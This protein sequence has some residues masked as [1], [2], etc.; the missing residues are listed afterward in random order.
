MKFIFIAKKFFPQIAL[1][2]LVAIFFIA[3]PKSEK[4]FESALVNPK[5]EIDEISLR[6]EK[7][8]IA[9]IS[10]RGAFWICD[11]VSPEGKNAV[12]PCDSKLVENLLDFSRSV[13]K[14]YEISDS[15]KNR[16]SLVLSQDHAFCLE[17]SHNGDAVSKIF[18]GA[19]DSR[20]RIAFYVDKQKKIYCTDSAILSYLTLSPDFWCDPNIFPESVCDKI[21]GG[22]LAIS[23]LAI[24]I[25]KDLSQIARLRHGKMFL[26]ETPNFSIENLRHSQ[27]E[28]SADLPC[29]KIDDGKG[30]IYQAFFM[31][32]ESVEGDYFCRF[33]AIP[34]AARNES[35]ALAIKSLDYVTTVSAWT[36]GRIFGE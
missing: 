17:F 31:P 19:A 23:P 25:E 22:T 27:N 5:Y 33:V 3:S 28:F 24:G 6:Y 11:Y 21:D 2:I 30:N 1:A 32:T 10:K 29:A 7:E 12:F 18:F 4:S 16:D 20:R 9:T 15:L 36:F 34:S 35:E 14:V 8:G 26:D 13:V